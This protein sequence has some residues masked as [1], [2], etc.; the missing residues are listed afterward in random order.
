MNYDPTKHN[1]KTIRLKEFD[2][3]Q[4]G[5]YFVTVV[6]HGR[7]CLFGEIQ[8]CEM[9][10]NQFGQIVRR[11]WLDLPKH[12]KQVESGAFCIMPNHVHGIIILNDDNVGAGLHVG[13]NNCVNMHF[14]S[15]GDHTSPSRPAPTKTPLSEIIRALKSFSARRINARRK[16][17]G[18][19][20]WQRNYYEHVIRNE[21]DFRRIQHY[22]ESNPANWNSD[23]EN[24]NK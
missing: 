11:A 18:K 2:Y 15:R 1:R 6:T 16:M 10:L 4:P 21:D 8:D 23:D 19:P 13:Q 20:V 22:I 17:V 9:H 12:Y 24:L 14:N 3:S 5:A 7:L